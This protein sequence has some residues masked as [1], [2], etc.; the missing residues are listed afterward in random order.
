MLGSLRVRVWVSGSYLADPPSLKISSLLFDVTTF[1]PSQTSYDS[2][3]IGSITARDE[4]EPS[5]LPIEYTPMSVRFRIAWAV[6]VVILTPI[7]LIV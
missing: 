4:D 5:V 7:R 1:E 2:P 6:G 3:V